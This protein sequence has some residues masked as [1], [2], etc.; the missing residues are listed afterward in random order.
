MNY[1]NKKGTFIEQNY[2]KCC[3]LSLANGASATMTSMGRG[4]HSS[5][6][7]KHK[8]KRADRL[9]SNPHILQS[10]NA[11]HAQLTQ[12]IIGAKQR[13]IISKLAKGITKR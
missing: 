10:I 5:A 7:E 11:C 8:I 12:F 6:Y 9:L 13:P 1:M 2:F 4:L 3:V